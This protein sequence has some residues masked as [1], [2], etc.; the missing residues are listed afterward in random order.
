[1]V[2]L[3]G[4][5]KE[6]FVDAKGVSFVL[7]VSGCKHDCAGCQSPHTH[8]FEVGVPIT[9]NIIDEL[10]MEIDKRPFLRA[11]VLSGGDPM[12]SAK[13]LVPILEKI[14]IPKQTVWCYTGFDI[15]DVLAD[16]DMSALAEKCT[17]IVDGMFDLTQRDVSLNFRGSAN[18]RIWHRRN[19]VWEDVT[20]TL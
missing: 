12:Y 11:L 5:I 7:F 14:H 17:Y 13:E 8:S 20:Q 6:S 3:A 2:R 1:M 16:D 19:E 15:A 4:V 10:N 18:Q 9:Q